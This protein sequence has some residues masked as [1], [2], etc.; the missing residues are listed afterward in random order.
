[1]VDS[2]M[3]RFGAKKPSFEEKTRFLFVFCTFFLYKP[4]DFRINWTLPMHSHP[5]YQEGNPCQGDLGNF[6]E[7]RHTECAYYY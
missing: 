6:A 4:V 1:M 5:P 7:L 3:L 2:L